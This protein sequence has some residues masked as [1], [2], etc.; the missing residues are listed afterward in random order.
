MI[1]IKTYRQDPPMKIQ[2]AHINIFLHPCLSF[3]QF[4]GAK[5]NQSLLWTI[6]NKRAR[7][8]QNNGTPLNTSIFI[9]GHSP[10]TKL[11]PYIKYAFTAEAYVKTL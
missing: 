5:I 10:P 9:S 11:V 4:S 8:T 7:V 3:G 6:P 1:K 2:H